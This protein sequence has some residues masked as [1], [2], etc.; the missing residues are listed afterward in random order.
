MKSK[1]SYLPFN[2][3]W[4]IPTFMA[5]FFFTWSFDIWH[6]LGISLLIYSIDVR[7]ACSEDWLNDRVK[8]LE[9]GK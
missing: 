5:A 2:I 9:N 7:S 6:Q 4:C 8:N 3:L 1:I